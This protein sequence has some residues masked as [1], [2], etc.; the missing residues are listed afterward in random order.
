MTAISNSD[1]PLQF[2]ALSSAMNDHHK[3]KDTLKEKADLLL[4]GTVC[5]LEVN[6]TETVKACQKSKDLFKSM[7]KGKSQPFRK[8][9]L[10]RNRSGS[11]ELAF[12][13]YQFQIEELHQPAFPDKAF[14]VKF[15]QEKKPFSNMLPELSS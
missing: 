1:L 3:L 13:E 10:P 14:Q 6:F 5:Y 11:V 2:N 12:R 9:L 15:N 4:G 7:R 8:G